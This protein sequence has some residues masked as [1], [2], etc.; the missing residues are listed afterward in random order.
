MRVFAFAEYYPN[1]FKPYLDTQFARTVLDG[2]ELAIFAFGTWG[3]MGSRVIADFRLAQ[4]TRYL[5]ATVR[6]LPRFVWPALRA[7]L[8]RGP[9]PPHGDFSGA[10]T[11]RRRIVNRV[12]RLLLPPEE[13]DLCLIH[14][15]GT[16]VRLGVI[17][18]VYPR[19]RVALYYHAGE[20]APGVVRDDTQAR[21]GWALA[22]VV[23][24]NTQY[25]REHAVHRGC[26]PDRVCL[27]PV[28]FDLTEFPFVPDRHDAGRRPVRLA[29]VGRL[30]RGKGVEYAIDAMALLR[31]RG[32]AVDCTIIG[33]GDERRALE[34]LAR[35]RGLT[36]FVHFM[37]ARPHHDVVSVLSVVDGLLL[38]SVPA[39]NWA[40]AQGC[41]LQEAM[42]VG[43]LVIASRVGGVPESVPHDM[44]EFL[45]PPGNPE[46]I[47]TAVA[48]MAAMPMAERAARVRANRAFCEQRFDVRR[49]NPTMLALAMGSVDSDVATY[50]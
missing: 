50:A 27:V 15:L 6:R 5:P 7:A 25:G 24:V 48:R 20:I 30:A 11:L 3:D 8:A 43:A 31:A 9:R 19:S 49:L 33:D 28:G 32:V 46:A 22:D 34:A 21:K 35:A 16:A 17:R 10:T 4:R 42:L 41:V 2:H 37:G 45:V 13:P 40:E 39:G 26:Q 44:H 29:V 47:A 36:P 18:S 38:P 12:Q 14:D 23:F 1:P